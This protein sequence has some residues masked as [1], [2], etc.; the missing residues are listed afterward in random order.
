MASGLD[1]A[2]AAPGDEDGQV[3]VIVLIAV[4][5]AVADQYAMPSNV[6]SPSDTLFNR[7][8]R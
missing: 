8:S 3:V 7:F 2:A 1:R 4:A 6:P 5:V